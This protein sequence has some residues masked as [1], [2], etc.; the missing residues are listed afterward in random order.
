M[1][2]HTA[3]DMFASDVNKEGNVFSCISTELFTCLRY[4][5]HFKAM[6]ADYERDMKRGLHKMK[7][8]LKAASGS[9][10][11]FTEAL[12]TSMHVSCFPGLP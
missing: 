1:Q 3:P 5:C 4:S 7:Y 11:S 8:V 6:E 10:E 2:S 9:N 12:A